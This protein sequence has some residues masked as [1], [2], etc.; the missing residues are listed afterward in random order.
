MRIHL[1]DFATAINVSLLQLRRDECGDWR[2]GGQRG[3][4][5]ADGDGWL[6][7]VHART[8]HG[9]AAA[10]RRL[11]FCRLTQD[12]DEEGCLHLGRLPDETEAV[13]IRHTLRLRKRREDTAETLANSVAQ[14]HANRGRN[15]LR[16]A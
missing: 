1:S 15:R 14:L 13:H 7:V 2:I 3:H 12:G 11:G 16:T 4:V 10:K 6:L 8:A 9:W 5:Y